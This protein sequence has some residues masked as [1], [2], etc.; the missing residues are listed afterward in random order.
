MSEEALNP[1]IL[2]TTTAEWTVGK[3]QEERPNWTAFRDYNEIERILTRGNNHELLNGLLETLA[4]F[5]IAY[6]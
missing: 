6:P 3:R 2:D 5:V 1:L 4:G